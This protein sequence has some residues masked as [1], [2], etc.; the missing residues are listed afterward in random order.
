MRTAVG[1]ANVLLVDAGDEMQGSLLSNIWQ[2][3]PVIDAYSTMGY[4][5][6]TFGNHEFDWGQDVLAART[7]EATYPY[8]SANIVVNDTGNC[9][10]AGWTSPAFASPYSVATVGTPNSVTVGFIGVT[11]QE[12]PYIT[13]PEATEGLCFKDPAASIIHYYD[14]L[15]ALTDVIVVLS[16][17]GFNDGGYG[18]GF[19]VYGDKTL[20]QNLINAGKPVPLIIG[21]H[22]HTDLSAAFMVGSTAVVQAHYNGR[23]LGRADITVQPSGAVSVRWQRLTIGTSDPQDPTI[24]ALIAEYANDPDYQALINQ[25]IGYAQTDLLRNYNGD[26]MMGDFIDD[27]IYGASQH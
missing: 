8:L 19:T 24:A 9:A 20:A 25:P 18:Y 1:A 10:T 13:I 15:D 11:S 5:A 12:T 16:H 27:A 21:G 17:L 26:N 3:V 2:G 4:N 14:E 7:D 6:A 22:S 23:K